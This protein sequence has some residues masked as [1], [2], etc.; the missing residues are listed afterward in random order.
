MRRALAV[1]L[2][3]SDALPRDV[4]LRLSRDIDSIAGPVLAF[5]P[6][7]SDEDLVEIVRASSE[8]KQIAVAE[9]AAL[10]APVAGA[11]AQFG[12]QAAA[13]RRRLQRQRRPSTPMRSAA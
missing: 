8:A 11:V 7:F 12:C 10:S 4:A 3:A 9:R 2:K 1:T 13:G 6:A 5:S